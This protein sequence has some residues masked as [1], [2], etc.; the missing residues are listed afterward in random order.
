MEIKRDRYLKKLL[1]YQWD[2]QV[3]IITVIRRCGKSYLL[4]TLFKNHLQG[5]KENQ[6]ISIELDLA[7]DIR[8]RNPL[9]LSAGRFCHVIVSGFNNSKL[10]II[11]ICSSKKLS[12]CLLLCTI[13]ELNKAIFMLHF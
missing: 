2:G 10:Y 7:R 8:C 9:E 11:R 13:L 3:K 1:S 5:V 12:M 4:H 6:I